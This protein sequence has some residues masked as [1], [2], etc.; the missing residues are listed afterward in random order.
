[1]S[2]INKKILFITHDCSY[3]GAP[4]ILLNFIK[5]MSENSEYE[6]SIL[7]QHDGELMPEYEKYT[8]KSYKL[9][10]QPPLKKDPIS[11]LKKRYYSKYIYKWYKERLFKDICSENFDIVFAN[12]VAS[13]K[14]FDLLRNKVK[15]KFISYIL[16]LDFTFFFLNITDESPIISKTDLNICMN[17]AVADYL[18][19]NKK[20][21]PDKIEIL[22]AITDFKLTKNNKT[23]VLEKL[24]IPE[25][26]YIIGASGTVE[27]RKGFD[28][29]IQLAR[30]LKYKYGETDIYFIWTGKIL[31]E[32]DRFKINMDIEKANLKNCVFFTDLVTNVHDYYSAFD[33]FTL[34]SREEALGMV[35]IENMALGNPVICFEK[36]GGMEEVALKKAAITVPYLDS[37]AMAK[38]IIN[39]KSNA[40]AYKQISKLSVDY[41][42]TEYDK[43]KIGNHLLDILNKTIK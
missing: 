20:I 5:W 27:W 36:C 40:E 21:R 41:V 4:I 37:D 26:A 13:F 18:I 30:I 10:P 35:C 12:S 25:N 23:Y 19:L 34:M 16:E 3:T 9:Y 11:R 32:S 14:S 39:L 1:M 2:K 28:L 24:G 7:Y 38:E 31:D 22:H 43:N 33:I 15:S 42:Q 29:F 6:C 17:K 8:H